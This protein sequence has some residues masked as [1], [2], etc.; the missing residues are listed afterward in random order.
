MKTFYEQL[1]KVKQN[2]EELNKKNNS[3]ESL[4]LDIKKSMRKRNEVLSNI[5]MNMK[6]RLKKLTIAKM[7]LKLKS[8]LKGIKINSKIILKPSFV[9][10]VSQK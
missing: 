10:L 6:K 3:R 7:S 9:V 5:L 2:I 4:I 8:D 1:E